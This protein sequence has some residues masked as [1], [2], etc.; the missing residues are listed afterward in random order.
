MK[1]Y[2]WWGGFL[3]LNMLPKKWCYA[4]Y[5]IH[6]LWYLSI[7]HRLFVV[8]QVCCLQI[9]YVQYWSKVYC[10]MRNRSNRNASAWYRAGRSEY[11]IFHF[12]LRNSLSTQYNNH[13]FIPFR[14]FK[15][16]QNLSLEIIVISAYGNK[17]LWTLGLW[18]IW[19]YI[20]WL[21]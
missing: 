14:E 8:I 1:V 21:C 7:N 12:I 19:S 9:M 17:G 2:G 6:T 18:P 20:A 3:P 16:W 10:L 4:V 13:R 15:W 5:P 11:F